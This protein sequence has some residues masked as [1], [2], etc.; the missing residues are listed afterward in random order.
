MM[1]NID[2]AI[3]MF[4]SSK[5]KLPKDSLIV[6]LIVIAAYPLAWY[7]FL[8]I[9]AFLEPRLFEAIYTIF[10]IVSFAL[11]TLGLIICSMYILE[12]KNK[13]FSKSGNR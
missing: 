6:L 4:V 8:K 1:D 5:L 7:I 3:R 9:D 10:L 12:I 13:I 11:L 2:N